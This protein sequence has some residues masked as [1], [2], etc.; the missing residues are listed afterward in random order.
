MKNYTFLLIIGIIATLLI[1]CND[2]DNT[3]DFAPKV[4]FSVADTSL[5]EG[6][7]ILPITIQL[8]G[9]QLGNPIVVSYE[10][11]GTAQEGVNY[12]LE[13]EK[14]LTIA[15]NTSTATFNIEFLDNAIFEGDTLTLI[16]TIT[17]AT[18]GISTG[19]EGEEKRQYIINIIEDECPIDW[20]SGTFEVTTTNVNPA[21]CGTQTNT[22][23]ITQLDD[24][25]Y[26]ITDL[27]G[28]V[29]KNCFQRTDNPG[30]FRI[31]GNTVMVENQP[32]VVFT[33]LGQDFIN[34]QGEV[35]TCDQIF[36][37]TWSN[38]FGDMG[39]SRFEPQ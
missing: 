18:E 31:E 4:Q 37:L 12:R 17:A 3:F 34:G 28:G 14:T 8:V 11:S 19:Q 5:L 33:E 1:S 29:Y 15:P 27:T 21:N 16:L 39:T 36:T 24:N 32:D 6:A 2:F 20:L 13:T 25:T 7:T 26:E 10:T 22:V 30:Q 23:T 38:G 35:N 9:P